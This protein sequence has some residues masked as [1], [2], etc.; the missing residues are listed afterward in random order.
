M[1]CEYCNGTGE[2]MIPVLHERTKL[3]RMASVPC[4][5]LASVIVSRENKLIQYLNTTYL[6]P[7]K[8]DPQLLFKPYDLINSPN[9]IITGNYDTFVLQ[10]K[11]LLMKNRFINPKPRILFARSIDIV[12]DYYIAKDDDTWLHLSAL[13]DFDLVIVN[14]GT[15]EKNKAIAPCMSHLAQIR[16]EEKKPTW[17]YLPILKPTIAQC[18]QEKSTELEEI[19]KTYE[20]ITISSQNAVIKSNE[21]TK[22]KNFAAGFSPVG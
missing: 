5:C 1:K 3:K 11:S 14:F 18:E 6:H 8:M 20:K 7:D 13:S 4:V 15:V 17:I 10:I 12:Q 19:I 9:F 2:T 21:I 22:S 16:R